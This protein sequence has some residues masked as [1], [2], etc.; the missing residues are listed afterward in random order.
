SAVGY[1]NG[2][3]VANGGIN[4]PPTYKSQSDHTISGFIHVGEKGKTNSYTFSKI[5]SADTDDN[6]FR[7]IWLS[8]YGNVLRRDTTTENVYTTEKPENAVEVRLS[9]PS[10][11]KPKIEKGNIA[12]DWTPAPEDMASQA[13]LSV[14]NDNINLRVEN[15]EL[16]SQI[17]IEAGRTLIHSDKS[18][19]DSS[20]VVFSGK[21]FIPGA[22]IENASID[23]AKIANATIGSA[24]I[25]N[26]DVN[27]ISGNKAQ[28]V[29]AGFNGISS[30]LTIDYRGLTIKSATSWDM[31]LINNGIRV[32][33]KYGKASGLFTALVDTSTREPKSLGVVAE[34]GFSVILG[35]RGKNS[36]S[37]STAVRVDGT[38]GDI[39]LQNNL[40]IS[41]DS[42]RMARQTIYPNWTSDD[43]F[44]FNRYASGGV[45]IRNSKNLAGFNLTN[46]GEVQV[47]GLLDR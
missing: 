42:I 14:L 47:T 24:K 32:T 27:K 31:E 39:A 36:S 11:S 1:A 29:K 17:N 34:N 10:D 15:G 41:G 45:T 9:F 8:E 13:Q 25:A 21:A 3:I 7:I 22:V 40:S 16:M 28:L 35:Y 44:Y 38:S 46:T 23:G 37:W 2:Y 12:T 18:Y 5:T 26:L 20:S 33:D 30:S 6:W 43:S 4:N 19:L